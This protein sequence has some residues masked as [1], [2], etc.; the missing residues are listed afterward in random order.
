MCHRLNFLFYFLEN[1][2]GLQN[3]TGHIYMG[4]SCFSAL[5][6]SC[7]V[8]SDFSALLTSF[9][10]EADSYLFKSNWFLVLCMLRKD[11][12]FRLEKVPLMYNIKMHWWLLPVH[13]ASVAVVIC[14]SLSPTW[15]PGVLHYTSHQ[16]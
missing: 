11:L 3:N 1:E 9:M 8:A 4:I 15:Y 14:S 16:P 10:V 2:G 13:K 5:G 12:L 6:S 7:P